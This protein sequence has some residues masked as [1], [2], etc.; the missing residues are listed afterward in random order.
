[1][2]LDQGF[3]YNQEIPHEIFSSS[4][5]Y[6]EEMI[7]LTRQS[8]VE[9]GLKLTEGH[10]CYFALPNYESPS[11]IQIMHDLGAATVGASTLPE[12]IACYLS[13][14]RRIVISSATSPSAGMS[15][16]EIS[17]EEVLDCGRKCVLSYAKLLPVLISK[18]KDEM[19][20]NK[21]PNIMLN[22]LTIK[23]KLDNRRVRNI[24]VLNF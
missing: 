19:F 23:D 16:Q 15:S 3:R 10:Y 5:I 13:G 17:G 2:Y 24:G 22:R 1:M 4:S 8:F 11:E 14:M 18:L 20:Q 21:R 7:E 9:A 6:D 12:Q